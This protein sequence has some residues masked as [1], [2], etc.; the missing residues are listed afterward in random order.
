MREIT[1]DASTDEIGTVTDFVNEALKEA[2]CPEPV[3]IQIDIAIDEIFGNIARYAYGTG[4]GRTTVRVETEENPAGATVTFIDRGVPYDP[5]TAAAPDITLPA[6]ERSI[7]GLGLFMVRKTM[8]SV[9]YS[10][11][12]GMNELSIRKHF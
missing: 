5:L 12:D 1:T 10:Y 8:D 2:E 11:R 7:G 4:H 6:R 9:S 3:R